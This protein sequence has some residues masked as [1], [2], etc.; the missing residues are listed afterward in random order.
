MLLANLT[1]TFNLFPGY[2]QSVVWAGWSVGVEMAFYFVFPLLFVSLRGPIAPW[3]AFAAGVGLTAFLWA[4]WRHHPLLGE[5]VYFFV[6]AN[7]CTFLA[8]IA[9][10]RTYEW[11][12]ADPGSSYGTA[13]GVLCLA[14]LA[15]A[16]LDP[17]ALHANL[18][19]L[20]FASWGLPFALACL[21][22]SLRPSAWLEHRSL[23]WLGD[24]S[25]SIYLLHPIVIELARPT[26]ATLVRRLGIPTEAEYLF[27]LAITL[28]VLFAAAHASYRLVAIPG[29]ALG[30]WIAMK[31][32]ESKGRASTQGPG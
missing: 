23:Q 27:C 9:A 10:H 28:P 24:R 30:R 15:C 21:W 26:Y 1:F 20:Y 29:M 16:Y 2:E 5:Y 14:T 8:G 17:F 32:A 7:L 18:P 22:Q 11:L 12:G 6:G 13:A 4:N 3:V 31:L 19:G 25:Y